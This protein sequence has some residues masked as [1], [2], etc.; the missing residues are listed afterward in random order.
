MFPALLPVFSFLVTVGFSLPSQP[1]SSHVVHE[2]RGLLPS[3]WTA[4]EKLDGEVRL[5]LRIGLKQQNLE[6]GPH[7]LDEVSNPLS[8]KYAQHWTAQQVKDMFSP[9]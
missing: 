7:L 6:L 2:K 4:R 9:R 3:G 1:V 8:D 5:P